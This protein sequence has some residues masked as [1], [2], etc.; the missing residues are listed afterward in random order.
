ML[1]NKI[2]PAVLL[3]TGIFLLSSCGNNSGDEN[4]DSASKH[5]TAL[6][7]LDPDSVAKTDSTVTASYHISKADSTRIAD[8]IARTKNPVRDFN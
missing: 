6:N 3:I 5:D 1:K 7:K 4:A 8:S 2:I